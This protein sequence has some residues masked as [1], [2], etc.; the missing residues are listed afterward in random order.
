[1]S[2]VFKNIIHRGYNAGTQ[3]YE[4]GTIAA[5]NI[6]EAVL[7]IARQLPG[8]HLD[9]PNSEPFLRQSFELFPNYNLYVVDS[10][11]TSFSTTF[12]V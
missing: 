2:S 7:R 11:S 4:S 3:P 10:P 6:D 8:V 9:F 5:E 1:M 12:S